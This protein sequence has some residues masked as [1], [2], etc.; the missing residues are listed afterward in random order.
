[1]AI[2]INEKTRI[3]K[4]S[5]GWDIQVLKGEGENAK[6]TTKYYYATLLSAVK[7]AFD[8]NI[9]GRK[10]VNIDDVDR[11]VTEE[12]KKFINTMEVK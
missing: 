9:S 6:W 12:L 1:M 2:S 11:F 7:S 8:M 3:V 4:S 10:N 5:L